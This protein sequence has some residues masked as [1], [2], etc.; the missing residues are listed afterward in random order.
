MNMTVAEFEETR[1]GD[2]FLK[3]RY[4]MQAK[5]ETIILT[6]NLVRMQTIELLNVQV[7]SKYRIKDPLDLWR[8][9]WEEENGDKIEIPDLEDENVKQDLKDLYSVWQKD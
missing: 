8:F 1:L 5:E 7:E 4:F 3:L 9:P 6:S 2:F